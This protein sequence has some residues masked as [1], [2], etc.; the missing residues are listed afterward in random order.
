MALFEFEDGHLVPAQFGY[1]VAQDLGPDLVDAICQQVLQ[2]V[3]RPLFPVTWRD[4]TGQDD[5][6]T[7]RLTALDVTGQIVSVEILKLLDSE[8]LI[9]S[10]SRLAVVA[11][12]SW[13]DLAAEYPSG[14]EGF[15]AG[16]AQFRD[17][18]PP[19]V[20]PGPR[21]IMVAG[22]ID[23][24]VRP[25]LSILATSGVEVHLMNL[26]Q[27]SNGRLFL[28]VNAVGPRLYGHAPQLLGSASAAPALPAA[29]PVESET[30]AEADEL[31]DSQVAAEQSEDGA[32]SDAQDRAEDG[33][34]TPTTRPTPKV[35]PHLRDVFSYSVDEEPPAPWKPAGEEENAQDTED[36]VVDASEENAELGDAPAGD[37]QRD[38]EQGEQDRADGERGEDAREADVPE[39]RDDAEHDNDAHG[40][41]ETEAPETEAGADDSREEDASD[42]ENAEQGEQDRADGERGEDAREGMESEHRDDADHAEDERGNAEPENAEGERV[43]GEPADHADAER[44]GD[45]WGDHGRPEERAVNDSDKNDN[46]EEQHVTQDETPRWERPAHL[47]SRASRRTQA[48]PAELNDGGATDAATASFVDRAEESPEVVAARD[49]GVPVL[50]RDEAGLRTLAQI[51][52]QDTPLV[53]R[54]ELGLPDDLVLAASGAISGAGLTYPSLET[55]LTARGMGHIDAWTLVR[56][57][58]RLGPTLAEALDEVNREIVREY[59]HAPR[60]RRA[61]RH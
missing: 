18:M 4:M 57:G 11:S 15:R 24:S 1:P 61:A 42:E 16:W 31:D 8:T 60:E 28:D 34:D 36:E 47:G 27:M 26:R 6:E 5:E 41:D 7:P 32:D 33:A 25:A 56:I 49:E 38:A 40:D 58:D 30:P 29:A 46:E 43:G 20:G 55:M 23:P 54:G 9:T 21:L 35:A 13:S 39:D 3:S 45:E 48:E 52:G 53:A 22:E 59:A 17:S 19:A 37:D 10:L 2:I 44:D 12:L 14:P 50:G 51:L